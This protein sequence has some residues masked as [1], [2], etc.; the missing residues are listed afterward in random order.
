LLLDA[1]AEKASDFE[2]KG[3]VPKVEHAKTGAGKCFKCKE[4]I[5]EGHLR[6]SYTVSFYHPPCFAETDLYKGAAER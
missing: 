1:S 2:V 4:P 6:V 5:Q 3:P